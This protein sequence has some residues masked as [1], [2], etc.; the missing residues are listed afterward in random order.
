M[1][2]SK[3]HLPI[4]LLSGVSSAAAGAG[5]SLIKKAKLTRKRK[6]MPQLPHPKEVNLKKE[7][8]NTSP[9]SLTPSQD[10]FNSDK[11]KNIKKNLQESPENF[12][13]IWISKDGYIIDGHHRW[14]ASIGILDQIPVIRVNLK[15]KAALDY[16]KKK[17]KENN[18]G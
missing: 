9:K 17:E 6:S 18:A 4:A 2:K 16:F 8:F 11:V 3:K 7:R 15:R 5:S 1:A 14:K 12:K 10:Y 13:P